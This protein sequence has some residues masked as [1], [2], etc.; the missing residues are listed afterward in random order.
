MNHGNEYF[1]FYYEL[2]TILA[3]V[4]PQGSSGFHRGALASQIVVGP[5]VCI[6]A[7]CFSRETPPVFPVILVKP[8][9]CITS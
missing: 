8:A 2:G 9:L 7:D 3:N 6:I 5:T 1:L 4:G